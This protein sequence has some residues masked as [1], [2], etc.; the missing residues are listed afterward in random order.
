MA[1]AARELDAA[2]DH[3][4]RAIADLNALRKSGGPSAD[5]AVDAAINRNLDE[6]D[7]AIAESRLA[8]AANPESASAR[9]SLFDALHQ[10]IGVL[11]TTVALVNEMRQGNDD[12]AA[13]AAENMGKQS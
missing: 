7:R 1:D 6:I 9:D 2:F 3:Y 8:L 10:K 11:E 13:R 5:P 4:Q 12:G